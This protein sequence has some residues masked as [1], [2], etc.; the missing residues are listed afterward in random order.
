MGAAYALRSILDGKNDPEAGPVKAALTSALGDRDPDARMAITGALVGFEPEPG[1]II[2]TLLEL[3]RSGDARKRLQA[4]NILGFYTRASEP[5]RAAVFAALGD[6]DPW[7]RHHSVDALGRCSTYPDLAP[8]PL[9][10]QIEAA[11][12]GA[13][14]DES[15]IVRAVAVQALGGL[16]SRTRT[17]F[18]VVIQ[19]LADPDADVRLQAA[20]FLAWRSPGGRSPALIP[21]L[22][23]ALRDPD[24]HVRRAAARTLG[25][26][27]PDAEATLRDSPA[28]ADQ[29]V[30]QEVA[31]ALATIEKAAVAL[32]SLIAEG[33]ANLGDADPAIRALG[34]DQLARSGPRAAEGIPALVRSL[35]DR[36][37]AVRLAAAAA[38][39]KLGPRAAVA[40][41]E[42][43]RRAESDDD[44]RVR[45]A[46][47][48]SRSVLVRDE[49]GPVP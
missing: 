33:I 27:G 35:G 38:L 48:A 29:E 32:R 3:A 23:R 46:A 4:V 41:P 14:G 28:D 40:M 39:G 11:V 21:A 6:A 2:P 22:G 24:K 25:R 42:L 8:Q 19:A 20:T 44:E 26:L 30:R 18:P 45:R 7:V 1:V 49:G 37:A 13:S 36:E 16:G 10:G 17:E 15:P 31:E 34:A 43:A 5:A 12:V 9:L 47:E